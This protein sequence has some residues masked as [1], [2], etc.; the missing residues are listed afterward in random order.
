M[1]T[2]AVV[3]NGAHFGAGAG[4]IHLDNVDCSGSE[5]SLLE[6][7]HSSFVTCSSHNEDAGVRC[8]GISK[9]ILV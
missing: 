6:C 5:D 7:S 8:Q 2:D 3:L 9:D 4:P 1:L